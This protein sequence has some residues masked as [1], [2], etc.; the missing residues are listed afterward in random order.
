MSELSLLEVPSVFLLLLFILLAILLLSE[1]V[2]YKL[3]KKGLERISLYFH[4]YFN[5]LSLGFFIAALRH[6]YFE[7]FG[8]NFDGSAKPWLISFLVIFTLYNLYRFNKW[9]KAI[10]LIKNGILV[11]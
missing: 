8:V 7:S 9:M 2:S 11:D 6:G 10:K 1:K 3:Y 5:F 4:I